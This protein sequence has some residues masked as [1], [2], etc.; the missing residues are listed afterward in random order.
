MKHIVNG[1][2]LVLIIGCL[3]PPQSYAGDEVQ[4]ARVKQGKLWY[5]KYCTPCHGPG[6]APG[7]AVFPT[8]KKP[9]DLRT[10]SERNGGEFP[11][12][13]WWELIFSSHPSGV[14]GKAWERVRSDQTETGEGARD[15]A[16]HS[17]VAN[18]ER[19]VE[20]IQKKN[21]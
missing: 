12:M 17:V 2:A 15:M 7:S 11:S 19:Y 6:G 4:D 9:I 5:D 8:T 13:K 1:L 18:I 14:H 10:I 20:S 16:A 3:T 21:K